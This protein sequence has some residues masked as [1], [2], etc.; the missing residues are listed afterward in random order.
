MYTRRVASKITKRK[1]RSQKE[2]C[3]PEKHKREK[4]KTKNNKIKQKIIQPIFRVL[5]IDLQGGR[6]WNLPY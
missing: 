4:T 1:N 6:L 3:G 2:G 5:S